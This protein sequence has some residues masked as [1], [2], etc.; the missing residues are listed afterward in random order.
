MVDLANLKSEVDKLDIGK[1][2][3]NPA[4]NVNAIQLLMPVI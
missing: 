4:K 2:Q 3:S 1:I